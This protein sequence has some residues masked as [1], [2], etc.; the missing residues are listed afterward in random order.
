MVLVDILDMKYGKLAFRR[1][2]AQ[3]A[4]RHVD[5]LNGAFGYRRFRVIVPGQQVGLD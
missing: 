1:L 3:E 4:H 2:S 5:A